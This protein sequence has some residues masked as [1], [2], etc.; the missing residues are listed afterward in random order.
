MSQYNEWNTSM[1]MWNELS[2]NQINTEVTR[3]NGWITSGEMVPSHCDRKSSIEVASVTK[4]STSAQS[5]QATAHPEAERAMPRK[6]PL[7][8]DRQHTYVE[9]L[10]KRTILSLILMWMIGASFFCLAV[11]SIGN[12]PSEIASKL[13]ITSLLFLMYTA[14]CSLMRQ[15]EKQQTMENASA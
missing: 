3:P 5:L 10:R 7:S 13:M 6:S 8:E 15:S 11:S 9:I 4:V 14:F 12:L 2:N 1:H